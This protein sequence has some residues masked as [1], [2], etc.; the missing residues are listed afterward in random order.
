[1]ESILKKGP[2]AEII[3]KL[4]QL[5]LFNEDGWFLFIGTSVLLFEGSITLLIPLQEAVATPQDQTKFPSL[6]SMVILGIITFYT[7]LE[8]FVG[9]PLAMTSIPS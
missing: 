6:Y 9:W 5:T 8:S 7:F 3:H 4:Q 1:M 2:L